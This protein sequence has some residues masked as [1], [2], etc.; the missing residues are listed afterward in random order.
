MSYA[1]RIFKDPS[2][3]NALQ[4]SLEGGWET[5]EPCKEDEKLGIVLRVLSQSND[6]PND[7]IAI[8]KDDY[9]YIMSENGKTS[10]CLNKPIPRIE[11]DEDRKSHFITE[12]SEE[13]QEELKHQVDR[14]ALSHMNDMCKESLEP[15]LYE[16]WEE[17]AS[18]LKNVRQAFKD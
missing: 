8:W 14:T 16:N 6:I 11:D 7:G 15:R 2:T 3:R 1:L 17:I 9:A 12:H 5:K 13:K 10:D 18:V 4:F